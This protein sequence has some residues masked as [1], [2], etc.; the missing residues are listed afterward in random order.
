MSCTQVSRTAGFAARAAAGCGRDRPAGSRRSKKK[1][2]AGWPVPRLKRNVGL[3]LGPLRLPLRCALGLE[4]LELR[5]LIRGEDREDLRVLSIAQ[6][7][8]LRHLR[9]D[10]RLQRV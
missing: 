10:G 7:F 2:Q 9:V 8:H 4:G 3:L 6:L 5:L 1:A